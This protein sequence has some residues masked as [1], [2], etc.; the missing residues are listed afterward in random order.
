MDE[1]FT[2]EEMAASHVIEGPSSSSKK[3]R[4]EKLLIMKSNNQFLKTI[5]F[6]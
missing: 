6:K 4:E 1:L 3:P 2:V 5:L